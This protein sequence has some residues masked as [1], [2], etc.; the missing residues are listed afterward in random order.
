MKR[1]SGA[2][3]LLITLIV[4]AVVCIIGA[5]SFK[6]LTSVQINGKSDVKSIQQHVDEQ[7]NEI[8]NLRKQ[9]IDYQ[10]RQLESEYNK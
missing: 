8:E 4:I 6:G 5:N 3:D 9:S 10:T 7:V 2:I 1:A